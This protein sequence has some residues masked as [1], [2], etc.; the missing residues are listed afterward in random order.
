[1]ANF[2]MEL[3]RVKLGE[4]EIILLGTAHISSKSVDDV[5]NAIESEK[6]DIVGVELDFNR[7]S[8][9]KQGNRWRETNVGKI[10]SSG[11]AF[12]FLFTLLLS[13][14]Q[15]S[16]G[17]KFGI[18]PGME[19]I[20]AV[21]IAEEKQIPIMLLD[22]DVNITLRRAMQKMTLIEKFRIFYW[23]L[24]SFFSE[25]KTELTTGT[26]E[27]LKEKDVLN[28]LMQELAREMPSIKSVL[29]DERDAFIAQAI[30]KAPGKK[31]LA[32]VGAGQLEGLKKG[33]GQEVDIA[34]ISSVQKS[35]MNVMKIIG[36]LIPVVFIAIVGFLFFTKGTSVTFTAIIY[37]ILA[38]GSLAA[39][40]T[41]IARGHPFSVIAAFLAAPI[42]TLH[43][44]LA[45]GWVAG[46]VEA[47]MR[48]PK[49]KDFENLGN[50]NSLDDFTKNQVTRILLVVALANLGAMIGVI[51]G[52]PL[53]AS[54]LG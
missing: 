15:R 53:L 3:E 9:L 39:L 11:Q 44:F 23:I 6:P 30:T 7:L 47:K 10:I 4:K 46:Y 5:A 36:Y 31:I 22:R 54:L 35:G 26:I 21:R 32:V 49:V 18:K 40:G 52:V 41:I 1:M 42:T 19:M 29:V 14:F 13:N 20:E 43:P 38:T 2:R 37:W 50:L 45:A 16:L 48:N 51:I 12:L 33:L 34:A 27:Q 24:M 8:Q 25:K 17:Q 28:A